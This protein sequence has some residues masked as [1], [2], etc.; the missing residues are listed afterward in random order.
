MSCR[1]FEEL[2]SLRPLGATTVLDVPS[3]SFTVIPRVS[4]CYDI[5]FITI[6]INSMNK[7][8]VKICA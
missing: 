3:T 1:G 4:D 8:I 7:C 5:S 6:S 2:N